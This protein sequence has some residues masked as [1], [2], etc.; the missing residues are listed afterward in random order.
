MAKIAVSQGANQVKTGWNAFFETGSY[1]QPDWFNDFCCAFRF[2][3]FSFAQIKLT[4]SVI[5]KDGLL[6]D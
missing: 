1:V 5:S 6:S 4:Q 2:P 3:Q